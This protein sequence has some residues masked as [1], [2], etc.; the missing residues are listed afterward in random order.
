MASVTESF[1]LL[2]TDN[3]GV[4][5]VTVKASH[6]GLFHVKAMLSDTT[7]IPMTG[8]KTVL[9]LHFQFSMRLM[10]LKTFKAR[11]GRSF[12]YI[13]MALKAFFGSDHLWSAFGIIMTIQACKSAHPHPMNE[14]VLVT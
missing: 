11:H 5:F 7:L 6:F 14:L 2:L 13:F 9:R 10:A 4:R 1:C 8:A 3:P 12:G